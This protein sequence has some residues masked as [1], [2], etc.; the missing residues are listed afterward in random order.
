MKGNKALSG[1]IMEFTSYN[2]IDIDYKPVI[3]LE[4]EELN[5][6]DIDLTINP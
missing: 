1:Y 4:L 6:D 2:K 3:K 5:N